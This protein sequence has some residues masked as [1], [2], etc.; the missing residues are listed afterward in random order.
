MLQNRIRLLTIYSIRNSSKTFYVKLLKKYFNFENETAEL[1]S[2]LNFDSHSEDFDYFSYPINQDFSICSIVKPIIDNISIYNKNINPNEILSTL[3]QNAKEFHYR[4]IYFHDLFN[5]WLGEY[6]TKNNNTRRSL[7]DAEGYLPKVWKIYIAIMAVSVCKNEYLLNILE[8]YFLE[9][10]G[11]PLWLINGLDIVPSKLKALDRIN[12]ILA[13][14][15]WKLTENDITRLT[16]RNNCEGISTHWNLNELIQG[17]IIL[18]FYQKIASFCNAINLSVDIHQSSITVSTKELLKKPKSTTDLKPINKLYA[19]S[20]QVKKEEMIQKIQTLNNEVSSSEEDDSSN[21]EQ[22]EDD[23]SSNEEV[24]YSEERV[25][26]CSPNQVY[27]KS[28]DFHLDDPFKL[29]SIDFSKHSS[30]SLSYVDFN[31]HNEQYLSYF[32]FNWEDQGIYVLSNLCPH[33][34]DSINKEIEFILNITTNSLGEGN[35]EFSTSPLRNAIAFY[36]EKVFGIEREDYNYANVNNL[37]SIEFKTIIKK[38]SS[39]SFQMQKS[40]INHLNSF[41]K[42][43][44]IV[45]VILLV[46]GIKERTQLIYF[47]KSINEI[48]KNIA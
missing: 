22:E 29:Y 21:G 14:C 7:F 45:H 36:I 31:R 26:Q 25:K 18:I 5:L 12:N 30:N 23:D 48:V 44:E 32:D 35:K 27:K 9:S 8:N 28:C 46:L 1:V 47:A 15:P 37:L 24:G 40:Y 10:D 2:F 20:L 19:K 3:K 39:Q 41:F 17:I 42:N 34:I 11:D 43:E 38:L 6:L 33:S 13:C 4:Y 16:K